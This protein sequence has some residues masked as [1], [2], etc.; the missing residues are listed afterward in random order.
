MNSLAQMKV[1][2]IELENRK[3]KLETEIQNSTKRYKMG[4][5]AVFIG[6]FLTPLYGLGFLPLL[7]GGFAALL[8]NGRRARFKDELQNLDAE[9][10]KLNISMV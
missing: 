4:L 10:H 6:I 7:A 1:Q 9:I 3:K 8:Y 2:L 5:W